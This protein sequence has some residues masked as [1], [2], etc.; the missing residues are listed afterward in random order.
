MPV[1]MSVRL[2]AIPAER[3]VMT[4]MLVMRMGMRMRHRFVN[5]LVRVIFGDVQPNAKTHTD[6]GDPEGALRGLSI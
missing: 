1:R 2:L 5:V 6:S 4:V 3:M